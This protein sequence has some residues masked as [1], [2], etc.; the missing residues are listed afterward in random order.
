MA[1]EVWE[2]IATALGIIVS[3]TNKRGNMKKELNTISETV[4]TLRKLLVKL[5]DISESKT[6]TIS[7]LETAD[8]KMRVQYEDGREKCNKGHAAPS[9]IISQKPAGNSPEGGTTWR[10]KREAL[11]SSPKEQNT[12]ATLQD[13]LSPKKTFQLKQPKGYLSICRFTLLGGS[14]RQ[15]TLSQSS[16]S[17]L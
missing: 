15:L 13:N 8:S 10:Q 12:T 4:S 6:K 7:N 17:G 3:T 2:D 1:D 16:Q 5:K 9:V 11:F 14:P